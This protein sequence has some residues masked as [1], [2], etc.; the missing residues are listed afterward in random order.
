MEEKKMEEEEEDEEEDK[1]E[2]EEEEEDDEE[3]K[4]EDEEEEEEEEDKEE[5]GGK[6]INNGYKSSQ[7]VSMQ[8]I[9]G[10]E[11]DDLHA[12]FSFFPSTTT[13]LL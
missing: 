7:M 1:E 5:V 13:S 10:E 11:G 9:F 12:W 4:E 6:E 3:D 2:D 8:I